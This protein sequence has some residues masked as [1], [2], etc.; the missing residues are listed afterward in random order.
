MTNHREPTPSRPPSSAESNDA[1][2]A[3]EEYAD[4]DPD[5]MTEDAIDYFE[6]APD[7]PDTPTADADAPPPG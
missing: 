2:D 1:A 5:T 6:D 4:L 7:E 3:R